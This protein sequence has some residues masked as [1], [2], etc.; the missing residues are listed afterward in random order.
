MISADKSVKGGDV[1]V[2]A[3]RT[4]HLENLCTYK[5]EQV[6]GL[7]TEF[8]DAINLN[9]IVE[10]YQSN[11]NYVPVIVAALPKMFVTTP[12]LI[13]R[14]VAVCMIPNSDLAK[15]FS[16]GPDAIKSEVDKEMTFLRF[17]ATATESVELAG[18]YIKLMGLDSLKNALTAMISAATSAL[19]PA[20]EQ[21][22][23]SSV[24]S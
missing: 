5:V 9:G 19:N 21:S 24:Q 1:V 6:M 22:P 4:I 15:L 11:G 2:I 16:A 7:L 10:A 18:D 8:G 20:T 13:L 3:G 12:T 17:N 23:D 14:S